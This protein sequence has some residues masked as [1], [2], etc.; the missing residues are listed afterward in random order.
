MLSA[1]AQ[2][3]HR[4]AA[5]V[6][7]LDEDALA[8]RSRCSEWSVADVL[9][10]GCD[11]D[12]WMQVIWAGEPLPFTTFDPRT[13]PNE[14][15]MTGRSIPDAEVRD[16][17]VASAEVM[18]VDVGNSPG[19]RWGLPSLS[20]LGFVPWWLS[21]LH[22]FW[23]SWVHERDALLPLGVEVPVVDDETLPTLA[24]C[25]AVV[26][27]FIHEPTDA[28][29]AGVRLTIGEGPVTSAREAATADT[30]TDVATII[31]ALSG[32]T[33][34]EDALPECDPQLLDRLGALTRM[35]HS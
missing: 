23:D 32:R 21:A 2:H 20:P 28:V 3:R 26:G 12:R 11:V 25:L 30:G 24:Y 18:A 4:F 31:D 7:G 33:T 10:H 15:V 29:V 22:I 17:Y 16:R 13:T 6:A 14:W 19:E 9:R 27:T 35:F 5:E 8:E 34:L 1:Y